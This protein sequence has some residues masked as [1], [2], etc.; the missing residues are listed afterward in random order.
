MLSL[1]EYGFLQLIDRLGILAQSEALNGFDYKGRPLKVHLHYLRAKL[2]SHG[3]RIASG[4]ERLAIEADLEDTAP[5]AGEMA[6]FERRLREPL[7]HALF[8]HADY[9]P[10][11]HR[12]RL[13]LPWELP[14]DIEGP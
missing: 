11:Q 14:E 10:R 12:L 6:P 1:S 13:S 9:Q 7:V 8:P 3:I 4:I 2:S 5:P